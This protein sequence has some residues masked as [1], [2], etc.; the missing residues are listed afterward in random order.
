MGAKVGDDGDYNAEINIIPLVDIMLVL[1][2]IFIITVPVVQNAVRVQMPTNINEP[3]ESK[4]EDIVLSIDNYST[5]YWND[6]QVTQ[7]DLYTLAAK[8]AV[9]K[10]MPTVKFRVDK[11]AKFRA[12]ADA[13]QAFQ[14]T[15]LIKVDFLAER[16][17]G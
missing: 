2:I 5:W 7:E 12:V 16:P 15:G 10:P 17:V 3:T 4:P 1:L 6:V 11:K 9:Q 13:M 8:A 14:R